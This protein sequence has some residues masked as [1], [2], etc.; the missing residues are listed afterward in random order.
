M[1]LVKGLNK[2]IRKVEKLCERDFGILEPDGADEAIEATENTEVTSTRRQ[3]RRR[4]TTTSPTT[5][6]EE[7]TTTT[8]TTTTTTS[9]PCEI[10]LISTD[11][12]P[13]LTSVQYIESWSDQVKTRWCNSATPYFNC[14]KMRMF[15][16]EASQKYAESFEYYSKIRNYVETESNKSCPGGIEGCVVNPADSRCRQGPKFKN[17][18]EHN[19][20]VGSIKLSKKILLFFSVVFFVYKSFA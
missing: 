7:I 10:E 6:T 8:M 9:E 20:A 4:R 16:C 12:H 1:N 17:M 14:I 15:N 19:S 18:I 11:C 13:I 3:K 2:K 5:T